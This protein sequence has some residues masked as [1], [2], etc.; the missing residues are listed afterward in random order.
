MNPI[1]S[2]VRNSSRDDSLE[3]YNVYQVADD[4]TTLVATTTDTLD[5]IAVSSNYNNYCY[6][7]KA[8]WNTG[9]PS[10]GGYGILESR[11][12]N[13]ACAIPYSVGDANF[14]SETTIA[15]VLALVDFILQETTPNDAAFNN[16]DV[17]M[18]GEL[19][20]AD[21][22]IIVDIISGTATGRVSGGGSFAHVELSIDHQLSELL[23]KLDYGGVLKGIQ[24][25]LKYNPDLVTI[26]APALSLMQENV[27]I[28]HSKLIDGHMKV[29]IADLSGET[30]ESNQKDL[31]KI[32]YSFNGEMT[33]VSGI[34][35]NDIF[36]SGPK[37]EIVDVSSRSV[38]L[39]V[40]LVP[41]LFAL[42]QNYPNP[43][44]PKTEIRFDL[45]EAT[46]VDISIYNLMGQKVKTLANK[47]VSPGYHVMQ[48][49]GT[50]DNGGMVST[51]MYFYTLNTE[52]FHAMRK[53]L[54]LK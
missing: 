36:V 30:V 42:H 34:S 48:W 3:V 22:V 44:N 31:V 39:D 53:M 54:F 46:V 26:N 27:I 25:D 17:N 40:Q 2:V 50:N 21:V 11:P 29:I 19:N 13:T 15:D 1:P 7:V 43:F 41:N 28:T 20:V 51:G 14:D 47:E 45:P 10:A 12:S 35:L 37:G 49:D 16:T 24:F 52:K 32:P 5:T 8:Q 38:S 9:D 23:V 33:D 6:E 18:D 4:T